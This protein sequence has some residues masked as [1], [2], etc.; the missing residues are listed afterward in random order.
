MPRR[1]V[2]RIAQESARGRG[3]L[4]GLLY[5]L[6]ARETAGAN[7]LALQALQLEPADRVLE[8]GF[9][10]GRTLR[11]VA[12]RVPQGHVS[13][14]DVSARILPLARRHNRDLIA[15]GRVDL[16]QG[17]VD[18]IPYATASFDKLLSVHTLY[19]WPDLPGSLAEIAR[20]LVPGGKLV[21]GFHA[22][23]EPASARRFPPSVYRFRTRREV[24]ERLADTGFEQIELRTA[25]L[26]ERRLS[27]ATARKP[28]A[29]PQVSDQQA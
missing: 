9:G 19:F 27:L 15:S 22:A 10:H 13:G 28:E 29:G 25:D 11:R 1:L 20:V 26:G 24:A 6:M 5:R 18:R 3:P 17:R 7:R 2:E 21:L 14:I 12:G 23:D 4:A 8:I 16:R